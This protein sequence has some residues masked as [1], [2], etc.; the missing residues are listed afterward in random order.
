[1]FIYHR[2]RSGRSILGRSSASTSDS[3]DGSNCKSIEKDK[4]DFCTQLS[5]QGLPIM[6][7]SAEGM[8]KSETQDRVLEL[9]QTFD[10]FSKNKGMFFY[11]L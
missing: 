9:L 8:S 7:L 1:M 10:N 6:E 3:E 4:S 5:D 11:N 2:H